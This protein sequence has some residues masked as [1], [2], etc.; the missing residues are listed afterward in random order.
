[1]ST[2]I[3]LGFAG[4]N[5]VPFGRTLNIIRFYYSVIKKSNLNINTSNF[6]HFFGNAYTMYNLESI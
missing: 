5:K 6:Q 2:K 3:Y 4:T 1:M